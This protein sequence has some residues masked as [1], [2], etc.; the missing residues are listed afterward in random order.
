MRVLMLADIPLTLLGGSDGEVVWNRDFLPTPVLNLIEALARMPELEISVLSFRRDGAGK[1]TLWG[2]VH[3][4]VVQTPK[5]SGLSTL[6]LLRSRMVAKSIQRIRPD[7]VHGQGIEAGYAWLATLQPRPHLLTFHGVY[8][9]TAYLKPRGIWQRLGRLLQWA[10]LKK[11]KHI[12][13]I[14]HYLERWFRAAS[15][16]KVYH[17]P[18]AVHD[19]FYR[20]AP[21]ER[22]EFD[23]LYIGRITPAKGLLDALEALARLERVFGRGLK[24]AV[25]GRPSDDIIGENYIGQ[26]RRK[27]NSLTR[28]EVLFLGAVPNRELAN[29]LSVSKILILPSYGENFNMAAAEASAVGIPVVAYLVGGMPSVVKTGETGFLVPPGDLELLSKSIEELVGN[30]KLWRRFSQAAKERAKRW[31]QNTVALQTAEMYLKI[32]QENVL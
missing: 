16:A 1:G 18:N 5:G 8:G 20:I 12:I 24:M 9:V 2:R 30:E 28:S 7:V 32:K 15:K 26:C 10:T 4:E 27:A 6:Y 3:I 23:L 31:H 14:S 19:R 11:A 25:V 21:A 13:A 29:I 22:P 17:I